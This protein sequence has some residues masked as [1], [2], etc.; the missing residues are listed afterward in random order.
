[1]DNNVGDTWAT[2]REHKFKEA[3]YKRVREEQNSLGRGKT[4]VIRYI[5][6]IE[7]LLKLCQYLIKM[8]T[9]IQGS[10]ILELKN[11]FKRCLKVCNNIF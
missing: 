4:N 10:N 9:N 8:S 2:K 7:E 3:E 6:V 1:M 5:K 11:L